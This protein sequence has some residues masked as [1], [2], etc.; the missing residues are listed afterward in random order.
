[1]LRQTWQTQSVVT[2]RDR[3]LKAELYYTVCILY[4]AYIFSEYLQL[5]VIMFVF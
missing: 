5:Y 2:K 4:Y 3:S 1:M